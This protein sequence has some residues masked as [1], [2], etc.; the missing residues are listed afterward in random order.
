MKTRWIISVS[1]L[2]VIILAVGCEKVEPSLLTDPPSGWHSPVAELFVDESAFPKNWQI[3]SE[4]P[5]DHVMDS[6]VNHVDREWWNPEKGSAYISQSIWRAYTVKD[7]KRKYN[8]LRKS[9]LLLARLTPSPDD[10]YVEFRPP[11]EFSFQSQIADEFYI[12]CGWVVWAYCEVVARYHNYVV[13][14]NIPLEAEYQG[15]IR[16]GL[17]YAEIEVALQVMENKFQAFFN[18]EITPTP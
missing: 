12:A 17:T 4:S 11:S 6:T 5:Q 9:P 18:L 7:A 15:H 16:Q 2:V 3:S 1:L 13:D 8:E 14:F 10:F